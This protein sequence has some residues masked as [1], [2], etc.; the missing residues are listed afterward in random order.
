[1][2]CYH[3]TSEEGHGNDNQ[4]RPLDYGSKMLRTVIVCR[5]N[6]TVISD[7]GGDYHSPSAHESWRCPC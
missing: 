6:A 3:V 7:C 5:H 4:D 1:M 2:L